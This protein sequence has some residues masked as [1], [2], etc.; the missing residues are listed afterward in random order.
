VCRQYQLRDSNQGRPRQHG[1]A[2]TGGTEAA[3]INGSWVQ[4]ISCSFRNKVRTER[5]SRFIANYRGY[6]A[7]I[8]THRGEMHD[9]RSSPQA[10]CLIGCSTTN[11]TRSP[12][13]ILEVPGPTL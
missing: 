2:T 7:G 5:I 13:N 4:T 8:Y 9:F 11:G 6:H 12:R 10:L 1:E 3:A